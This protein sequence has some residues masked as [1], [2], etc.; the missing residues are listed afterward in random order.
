MKTVVFLEK[1]A[2]HA[3]HNQKIDDIINRQ[4]N[5]IS[6]AFYASDTKKIHAQFPNLGYLADGVVVPINFN[7]PKILF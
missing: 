3:H 5:A 2:T 7:N 1:L 4:D 6:S